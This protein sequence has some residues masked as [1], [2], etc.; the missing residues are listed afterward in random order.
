MSDDFDIQRDLGVTPRQQKN[1]AKK[2]W[3]D[4]FGGSPLVKQ[5]KAKAKRKVA[6]RQPKSGNT[7]KPQAIEMF[8]AGKSVKEVSDAL[9]ITYAN[10]NYYKR[11]I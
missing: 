1:I 6:Q 9:G 5:P 8:Q 10:A 7:L 11:C 4:L 2:F 3:P